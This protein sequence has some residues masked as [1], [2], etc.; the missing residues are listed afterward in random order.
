[1]NGSPPAARRRFEPL[2]L[3]KH[4]VR[5]VLVLGVLLAWFGLKDIHFVRVAPDDD[6]TPGITAGSK[7]LVRT[8]EQDEGALTR[9]A[10]Y[11]ADL[12]GEAHTL[13]MLRIVRLVG[14]PGDAIVRQPAALAGRVVLVLGD[15]RVSLPAEL[16]PL[17][18]DRVP[19][20]GC[21]VFTDNPACHHLD[22]RALGPL[23]IERLKLRVVG[24]LGSLLR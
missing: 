10:L 14:L 3:R 11:L 13:A 22:S 7:V 20:A 24:S 19:E 15:Q 23:P 5:A 17:F 18:P 4:L 6:S 16:A 9:G 21:L 12:T 2:R 8:R 1:V